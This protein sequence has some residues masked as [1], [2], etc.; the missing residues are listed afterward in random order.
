MP[1]EPPGI[2]DSYDVWPDQIWGYLQ[3]MNGRLTEHQAQLDRIER[4]MRA[5]LASFASNGLRGFRAAAREI[6]NDGH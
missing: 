3:A 1:D 4:H 5:L 6:A 2:T